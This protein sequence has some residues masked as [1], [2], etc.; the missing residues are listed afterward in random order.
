MQDIYDTYLEKEDTFREK[1]QRLDRLI[2]RHQR[3]LMELE[4]KRPGWYDDVVIPLAEAI[5]KVIE[6]P[7]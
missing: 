4:A 1:Q 7:Y 3:S 2:R 5:S 6:M